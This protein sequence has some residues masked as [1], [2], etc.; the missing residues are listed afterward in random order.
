[1]EHLTHDQLDAFLSGGSPADAAG[2]RRHLAEC[3]ACARR[4]AARARFEEELEQAASRFATARRGVWPRK[5][6]AAA[7]AVILFVA[8]GLVIRE[9]FRSGEFASA[10]RGMAQ[11]GTPAIAPGAPG[12]AA[13]VPSLCDDCVSPA[14]LCRD[15]NDTAW[16]ARAALVPAMGVEYSTQ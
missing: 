1:M 16:P 12:M 5:A 15:L 6:L 4:L 2:L 11:P 9:A 8:G 7:A 3:E 14:D 10:P 13:R